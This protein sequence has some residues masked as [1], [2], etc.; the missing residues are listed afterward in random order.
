MGCS[1]IYLICSIFWFFFVQI[2]FNRVP[3]F[4]LL[5]KMDFNTLALCGT[6][7]RRELFVCFSLSLSLSLSLFLV[8]V[9]VS[10]CVCVRVCVGV[11]V[12]LCVSL[13]L[14]FECLSLCL[15]L[16]L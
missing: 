11:C 13:F 14:I 4:I 3:F 15:S 7:Y 2:L 1:I 16:S 12:Y 6:V 9:C 10:L 5:N 8:S